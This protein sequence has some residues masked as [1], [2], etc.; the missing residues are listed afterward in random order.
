MKRTTQ[1]S[2]LTV[3]V[4]CLST[5]SLRAQHKEKKTYSIDNK[6]AIKL[7]EDAVTLIDFNRDL[8]RGLFTLSKVLQMEPNFIE[9]NK[10]AADV[11]YNYTRDY[12]KAKK[13]YTR[14]VELAP[15]NARYVGSYLNLAKIHA[16]EA[17]YEKAK[18]YLDKIEKF[19]YASEKATNI[20]KS[21]K[22]DMEY[23]L[24]AKN[25]AYEFKPVM[26]PRESINMFQVQ[27]N[28]VLTADQSQLIYS[29]RLF[30]GAQSD[31]NIVIANRLED[32]SWSKPD[33][34]S[35]IINTPLSEGSATISG[36]GK[37]LV[38]TS[39]NKRNT[40]G[41][42][43]LYISQKNGTEWSE[44]KNMLA[45]VNSAAWESNPAL[46]PDG[47]TLYFSSDR[48]GGKG[49]KDIWV[50]SLQPN[51]D[52][53]YPENLGMVVNTNKNEVTPFIHADNSH[54][55]FASDGFMGM[56]GYDLFYSTK[57]GDDW[58]VP[59]NLGY[60]INTPNNEGALY[61]TADYEKGYYEKY[62]SAGAE[63]HSEI[64]QFDIPVE[65]KAKYKCIYAKGFVYDDVSKTPIKAQIDLIDL[66]TGKLAQNVSS[67]SVNGDYLVVLNEGKEYALHVRAPGYFFHSVHFD[68]RQ[69]SFDPLTLDVYLTPINKKQ[70][71]TL[72][73]I[74]F[75]T[76]K[77]ELQD[78]STIELK[79]LVD[80]LK[81]HD[82]MRIEISGHTDN[83]G[84][85]TANKTLS[86]NRAKA[87]YTYLKSQGIVAS[88]LTF[89]GYGSSHPVGDNS[90]EEGRQKNRRIDFK[91]L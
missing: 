11:F 54:L 90:N 68:F 42:C 40:V 50:T 65:I 33:H 89:K 7:F 8:D 16:K 52:W 78:K 32:G 79:R 6:K 25:N 13:Y 70:P 28:P 82:G 66:E 72:S 35:K 37:T 47:K 1:I 27:S 69:G 88:R 30:R 83:I 45:P 53:D 64:Y 74:F 34:I 73:N 36:D 14:V 29:M 51:G 58:T 24:F 39:C 31:E 44:P 41:G 55:Y 61:I 80:L 91:L 67:D 12:A 46:S 4:L 19:P 71:I 2:L 15:E 38:F 76:G 18:V 56:G 59:E 49:G 20:A 10:K 17:D 26:L 21:M 62:T 3:F 87:V 57:V 75:E 23:A 63:S 43:D 9:A 48:K 85:S 81:E 84:S 86:L 5:V 60:P 77:Y 22:F